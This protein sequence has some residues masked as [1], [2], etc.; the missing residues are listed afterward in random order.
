MSQL[1]NSATG[2]ACAVRTEEPGHHPAFHLETQ[3]PDGMGFPEPLGEIIEAT[4]RIAAK[5]VTE[6]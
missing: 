3:S 1:G 2:P 4:R 5:A 6:L